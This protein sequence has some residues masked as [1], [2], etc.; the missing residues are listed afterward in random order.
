VTILHDVSA[1]QA[2][3]RSGHND[4]DLWIYHS[5]SVHTA[6]SHVPRD[7]TILAP[8]RPNTFTTSLSHH[9]LHHVRPAQEPAPRGDRGPECA[10]PPP[11]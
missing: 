8:H 7:A 6:H 10:R 3:I 5:I 4:V 11:R 2:R 9:P 1:I